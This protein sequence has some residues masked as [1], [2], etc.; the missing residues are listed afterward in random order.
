MA[1]LEAASG[2][3]L[4]YEILQFPLE[5][6]DEVFGG[7][8]GGLKDFERLRLLALLP[9]LP[10]P[11][12]ALLATEYERPCIMTAFMPLAIEKDLRW[13]LMAT[14]RGSLS[15]RCTGVQETMD[16]QHRSWRLKTA[17]QEKGTR[18][19]RQDVTSDTPPVHFDASVQF[20]LILYYL[21]VTKSGDE[22]DSVS[23]WIKTFTHCLNYIFCVCFMLNHC[24]CS[25]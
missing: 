16:R 15:M 13:D 10:P 5:D 14:G 6:A 11:A 25:V 8:C 20:V 9:P 3:L 17:E 4:H 23:S 19:L 22:A 18:M 24:N 21:D 1:P 7:L 2:P 12:A